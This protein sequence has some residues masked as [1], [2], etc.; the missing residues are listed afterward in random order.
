M[1]RRDFLHGAVAGA[2]AFALR[3][4]PS[5]S[6]LPPMPALLSRAIPSS[7]ERIP[8][9]GL[10]TWQAFDV[11]SDATRRARCADALRAFAEGGGT[12]IDSSPM[13]GSS[14]SVVGDLVKVAGV[15]DKLWLA[16]KVWTTGE[17]AGITQMEASLAALQSPRIALMQVHN[18]LDWRTHLRTLRA[19][20][21]AGRVKYIGVTH[22][23]ASAHDDVGR[24]LRAETLDFVQLNLSLDEPDAAQR[25]LGVCAERG[26]AFIA[27]RPFGGG[28]SFARA[29]GKPLPA[30][31]GE[32]DIRSWAQFML[33]WILSHEPVTC[34]IP[35]TSNAAHVSDNLAAA[36]GR[37]PDAGA[38]ARM[39]AEW[40]AL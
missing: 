24:V 27:N 15:R 4:G 29:R 32:Y 14:E 38:R 17:R 7:G 39:A 3:R 23:V 40:R 35:G 1:Q 36:T 28:A 25:M 31:A 13:Y 8:T 11:G 22:Y 20:R 10:G 21:D 18:L 33:K 34:A 12:V 37:L 6:N 16:T 30:W 19:W 2:I 5:G 9:V 26:V